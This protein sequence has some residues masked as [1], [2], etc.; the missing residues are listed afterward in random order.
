MEILERVL[1]LVKGHLI[2]SA[3]ATEKSIKI[4][5]RLGSVIKDIKLNPIDGYWI[6]ITEDWITGDSK[7]ETIIQIPKHLLPEVKIYQVGSRLLNS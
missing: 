4:F 3:N 5:I 2:D 6:I 7:T 1:H